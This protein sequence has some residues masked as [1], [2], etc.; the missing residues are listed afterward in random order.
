M[1]LTTRLYSIVTKGVMIFH[2]NIYTYLQNTT[3]A[4]MVTFSGLC[5]LTVYSCNIF[6]FTVAPGPTS[7]PVIDVTTSES[8]NAS[9]NHTVTIS[10]AIKNCLIII[11]IY[12]SA[13]IIRLATGNATYVN[14]S[15]LESDLIINI[16]QCTG[17]IINECINE[18]GVPTFECFTHRPLK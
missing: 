5:P 10:A 17:T 9:I 4:T 18:A 8:G 3:D 13:L 2:I 12:S 1:R 14:I 15:I 7:Y 6:A 16:C 11:I